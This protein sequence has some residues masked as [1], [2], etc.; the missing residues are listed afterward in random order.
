MDT[1]PP[2]F[3]QPLDDF[4][5]P[6]WH[7]CELAATEQRFAEGKE[8]LLDWETAKRELRSKLE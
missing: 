2:E 4:E 3:S 7:L 1:T 6:D 8:P 5:S